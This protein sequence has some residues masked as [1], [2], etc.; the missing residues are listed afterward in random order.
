MFEEGLPD[1][2]SIHEVDYF[3]DLTQDQKD[4]KTLPD[5]DEHKEI[6][7]IKD[8]FTYTTSSTSC[9][10]SDIQGIIYGGFSS[11]FWI[12]RKHLCCL[13]NNILMKDTKKRKFRG[14]N[15]TLP[16]YSWQ[17]LTLQ[18]SDRDVD[19]VIKDQKSMDLLIKFLVFSMN[20][21]DCRK[22]SAESHV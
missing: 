12:Y 19:L 3:E 6:E 2:H 8:R 10:I 16:F 13:D 14:G 9:L 11:R 1:H 7:R 17:C 5:Y 4:D 22:D 20:T 15:V 21:K 18:L